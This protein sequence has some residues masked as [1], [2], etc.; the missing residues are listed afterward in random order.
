M[1]GGLLALG[2]PLGWA[3][4]ARYF[5]PAQSPDHVVFQPVLY[6]YLTLPSLIVF[7]IF[8]WVLGKH[9]E[10]LERSLEALAHAH[11]EFERLSRTDHDT[12]LYNERGF[13]ELLTHWT[14]QSRRNGVPL[15]VVVWDLDSF[16]AL[17]E[18]YGR[19]CSR[20]ALMHLAQLLTHAE[21]TED[22][23]ARVGTEAFAALLP[24][25]D[26]A[27][28]H[29]VAERLMREVHRSAFLF[30]HQRHV[31]SISAGYTE[32]EPGD[33]AR[34][35]LSRAE[36]GLYQAKRSGGNV[37]VA[38]GSKAPSMPKSGHGHPHVKS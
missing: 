38:A 26:L 23:V 36:V 6:A 31:L 20:A 4:L 27:G 29:V 19:A 18:H 11:K 1:A 32:L 5:E 15:A 22:L 14:A 25:T 33:D 30:D 8:G 37:A 35:L 34:S 2:A 16:R 17:S 21:R 28:A 3:L 24:N 7:P 9:A 12:G 10:R 13:T